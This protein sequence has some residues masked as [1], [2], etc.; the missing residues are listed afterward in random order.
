MAENSPALPFK[1]LR[2]GM[3]LRPMDNRGFAV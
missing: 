1:H 3:R 2:K